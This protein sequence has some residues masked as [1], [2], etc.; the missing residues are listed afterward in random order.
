MLKELTAPIYTL[1]KILDRSEYME[2]LV[3]AD[4]LRLASEMVLDRECVSGTVIGTRRR[5]TAKSSPTHKCEI[6]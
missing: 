5:K 1:V 4:R 6:F 2:R 3:F